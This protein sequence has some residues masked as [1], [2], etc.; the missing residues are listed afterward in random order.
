VDFFSEYGLIGLG[1]AAFLA[2]IILPIS[3]EI[4][5]S[6]LLLMGENKW[7]LIFVATIGNVLGSIVNY[8]LG[9][10]SARFVLHRCFHISEL[11]T[12]K[13]GYYFNR[14]G[15]WSLLFSWLPIIGDPLTLIAGMLK[16]NFYLFLLLVTIGKFTRYWLLSIA[17][18][19]TQI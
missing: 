6:T 10:W 15:K 19:A 11:Q 13:A 8:I 7:L 1:F 3:S 4:V 17:I 16:V 5:L 18:I 9:R 12:E 14:Y 2:A